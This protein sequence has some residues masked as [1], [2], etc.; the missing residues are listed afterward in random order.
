MEVG[1]EKNTSY[2]A[3]WRPCSLLQRQETL[4]LDTSWLFLRRLFHFQSALKSKTSKRRE[5]FKLFTDSSCASKL[6][7]TAPLRPVPHTKRTPN[8]PTAQKMCGFFFFYA[9]GYGARLE[10][11]EKKQKS[12]PE[13]HNLCPRLACHQT[14]SLKSDFF[15]L[16][17]YHVIIKACV[18]LILPCIFDK[19]FNH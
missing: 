15:F 6:Q 7:G 5:V 18:A 11:W 17:L 1:R 9:K 2:R 8:E 3:P 10:T 4:C 16:V 12:W 14:C 13:L 19:S